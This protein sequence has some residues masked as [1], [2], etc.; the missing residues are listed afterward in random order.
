MK[1]SKDDMHFYI[2]ASRVKLHKNNP[3]ST[4]KKVVTLVTLRMVQDEDE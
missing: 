4:L 3:S 1:N 2:R